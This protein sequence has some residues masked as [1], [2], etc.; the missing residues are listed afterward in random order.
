MK[1]EVTCSRWASVLDFVS[2]E[3]CM[4]PLC[5]PCNE[6]KFMPFFYVQTTEKSSFL[7]NAKMLVCLPLMQTYNF[8]IR[9]IK[10]TC[11][12]YNHMCYL[13]SEVTNSYGQY[14]SQQTLKYPEALPV[15][16][17]FSPSSLNPFALSFLFRFHFS[18]FSSLVSLSCSSLFSPHLFSCMKLPS[19]GA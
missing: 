5:I 9:S 15:H 14:L 16:I 8:C 18:P 10:T 7:Q 1:Y 11:E 6:S 19:L 2:F 13:D 17:P 12:V 4:T 3:F